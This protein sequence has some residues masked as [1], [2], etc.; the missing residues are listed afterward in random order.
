MDHRNQVNYPSK[1]FIAESGFTVD[2]PLWGSDFHFVK[3]NL[4]FAMVYEIIQIPD[5]GSWIFIAN[6]FEWC[7]F[8]P[9]VY[10]RWICRLRGYYDGP[11]VTN[12]EYFLQIE[13][14]VP[15]FYRFKL[16]LFGGVGTTG[17][18]IHDGTNCIQIYNYGFGLRI[19]FDKMLSSILDS[20]MV[21]NSV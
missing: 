1:G 15:L 12:M 18:D 11:F 5:Y 16:A 4:D 13:F 17:L 19:L 6:E 3:F 14:R 21:K 7:T 20:T 9:D 10:I 8:S 2:Q